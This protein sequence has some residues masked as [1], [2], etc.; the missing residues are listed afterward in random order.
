MPKLSGFEVCQKMREAKNDTPVIIITP[1]SSVSNKVNTLNED[2]DDYITKPFSFVEVLARVKAVLRR[3]NRF[4]DT[5][6]IDNNLTF[7]ISKKKLISSS[8]EEV[9][10]T[11]KESSILKLFCL[12]KVKII[13]KEILCKE[14]WD[15]SIFP[16]TNFCEVTVKNYETNLRKFQVKNILKIFTEKVISLLSINKSKIYLTEYV[17]RLT[18][19]N[20]IIFLTLLILFNSILIIFINKIH[21]KD[22]DHRIEHEINLI[23][24]AIQVSNDDIISI[25]SSEILDPDLYYITDNPCFLQIYDSSNKILISSRNLE[26]YKNISVTYKNNLNDIYFE[27]FSFHNENFRAG[28]YPIKNQSGE[29]IAV[30][31]LTVFDKTKSILFNNLIIFNLIGIPLSMIFLFFLSLIGAKIVFKPLNNI[32]STAQRI[33]QNNLSERIIID[34]SPDDE[35]GKLRDTLNELFDKIENYIN[36]LKHFTDLVS[37]QLMNPITAIITE[38]EYVLKRDRSIEEYK[39][40]LQR[41]EEKVDSMANIIKTLLLI[42]RSE[43]SKTK[44]EF[45]FNFSK[46]LRKEIE[47]Y[48]SKN[49][50]NNNFNLKT[51]IEDELYLRGEAE[52]FSMVLQNLFSNAKKFSID[53][54]D[55][56]I[57]AFKNNNKIILEVADKGIGI[58]DDDKI[59][60]FNKFYRTEKAEK[61][62]ILGFGLGLNLVKTIV[63]EA[64]GKIEI[65]DNHPNGTII[66]ITL[67]SIE[68]E[69]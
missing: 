7:N 65:L 64:S 32:I 38:I 28:Y 60:V 14:I 52:K 35:I 10:L 13:N 63:E 51:H 25:D 11:D 42:A 36:E 12:N 41:L 18:F 59:K 23:T 20:T 58:D 44:S 29:Q 9:Y 67:P 61:L 5:I 68:L 6:Q 30:L 2:A 26:L 45:V 66:K 37:H 31:R 16:Q 19:T 47:N 17:K 43:K 21:R 3:S 55:V 24:K 69:D 56:T 50:L 15:M 48:F 33:N 1:L 57:K 46:L 49:Y 22:L 62:G 27:N 8:G 54:L 40:S 39:A 34:A 53:S 4:S